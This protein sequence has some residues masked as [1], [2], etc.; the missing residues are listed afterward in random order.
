MNIKHTIHK[1][2]K[3]QP[4]FSLLRSV[5]KSTLAI[6]VVAFVIL[7]AASLSSVYYGIQLNKSKE[8]ASFDEFFENA[9]VTKLAIIPNSLK[10]YLYAEPERITIDIKHEDFQRLAYKREIALRQG[11]LLASSDDMVS[12]KIRYKDKMIKAK[13]RLKGDWTDHLLGEKWSYRIELKGDNT[14]FGMKQ[15]SIHHPRARNYIYEWLYQQALKREGMIALRYD[16]IEVT[17]NGKDLGVY[18]IEEHFEKRLI[19]H[20]AYREG[21]ILKLDESLFWTDRAFSETKE[22]ISPTGVQSQLATTIDVFK[23]GSTMRDPNLYNQF[24]IAYNLLE[25][26]RNKK[27]PAHKAFN[28][29]KLAKLYALSDLFG[30]DHSVIWHNL[31][32]YY[33]PVTAKLEPIGFDANAGGQIVHLIGSNRA[34]YHP[35]GKFKDIAFSDLTFYE[36]YLEQVERMSQPT[37]IDELLS[38]VDNEMQAKLNIIY[39]DF[40]FFFFSKRVF[41]ENQEVIRKTLNPIKGVH[42][43]FAKQ[44]SGKLEFQMGNIQSMPV[45]V[46]DISFKDSLLFKPNGRLILEPRLEES[47]VAYRPVDFF[48]PSGFTWNDTMLASIK[49]NY[50]ILGT[51]VFRQENVFLWPREREDFLVDDFMRQEAN[52]KDF[53]FLVFDE[54]VK[55]IYIKSGQWTINRSL[56]IPQGYEVVAR[57]GTTLDLRNNALLMSYSPFDFCGS[58]D[59]PILIHSSDTTGQGVIVLNASDQSVLK[60]VIFDNLSNPSQNGWSVTSAV[61]FYESPGYFSYCQFSNNRCEDALNMIRTDYT[62][63][64][65]LFKGT[66]SD[67]FDGDF[68][69]GKIVHTSFIDCGNDGIDV[70]GSRIE[71]QNVVVNGSGDKGLSA[72]ENSQ[73]IA[74]NIDIRNAEIAVASKD[75]SEI[76]IDGIQ[77]TDCRIGFTLFQKKPEFDAAKIK[78]RNYRQ[79][80]IE[81]PF[82]V[83]ERSKLV[84]D[85]KT[86]P[87][88]RA[89]VKEIL[90][91]VEYGKSSK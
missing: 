85:G 52:A 39:K 9:V 71:V 11:I 5:K 75:M 65:S 8:A 84:I 59:S 33:N 45:E 25:G 64:H 37:Y 31:R 57:E 44:D 51:S 23:A 87:P 80:K 73:M 10:G 4:I 24:Q 19:E 86:I 78:V 41:Y 46:L 76:E 28:I 69:N 16:F 79:G 81:K 49:V 27:I 53:E 35:T 18:A 7:T 61:S 32:F 62:I 91:G 14:L 56:V 70:S 74:S 67:A 21:P 77:I 12:A 20:N 3:L 54:P 26:F 48:T 34:F 30:A 88:S 6:A 89:N 82:L 13:I 58:E 68:S 36:A 2:S 83:E 42:A 1:P 29:E 15:F 22:G 17:L 63:E 40:P 90:Y 50:K 55:K 38:A 43:Y 47:T 72:G 66:Q 60:Y